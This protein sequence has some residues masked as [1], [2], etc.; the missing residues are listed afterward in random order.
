MTKNKANTANTADNLLHVVLFC[1]RNKDN[2]NVEGF[3]QRNRKFLTRHTTEELEERFDEFVR[4]GKP[5]EMCRF[6]MSVNA[7]NNEK[8][9]R[10]LMHWL[11]D[12]P[13]QDM[14]HLESR[15]VSIAAKAECREENKWMFDFDASP[16]LYG[17]FVEDVHGCDAN[18][19]LEAFPTPN[20]LCVVASRGFDFRKLDL[21]GKWNEVGL[22]KDA[23]RC[24]MWKTNE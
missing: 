12:N 24:V 21:S 16:S 4:A 11:V 10:N 2:E 20:G 23:N 14:A 9:Q 8:V 6:Y 15:A 7:R 19:E 17:E 13:D 18:V 3:E 22:K 5:G 1:S